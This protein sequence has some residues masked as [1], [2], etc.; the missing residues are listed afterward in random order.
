[1]SVKENP[2]KL[3]VTTEEA[4]RLRK[5]FKDEKFREMFRE[6]AQEISDPENRR[7]Y[8]KEIQLLEQERGNTVEFIHPTPYR[9][10]RTS[11]DG[12]H[13]CFIN[14]CSSEKVGKPQCQSGVSEGGRRGQR[15]SLPHS[16]HPGR[17]DT[18]PKGNKIVVYDVVFHPDTLHLAGKNQRFMDMVDNTAISAIQD[19][20]KVTLD[21]NNLRQMK[22]KYKGTPQACVIRKPIPGHKPQDPS[23]KSDPLT[24]P[25][26]DEKKPATTNKSN[27][28]P[29]SLQ[30]QPQKPPEPTKPRYTVKYRSFVDLQDYRC[31]RD[32]A[33]SPR[34]KEI[35]VTIEVPLLKSIADTSLEVKERGLLLESKDPA[36]RLELP[37]AYPVDEDGGEAKFN[38]QRGQLSVT[39]PVLPSKEVWDGMNVSDGQRSHSG[40]EEICRHED[41]EEMKEEEKVRDDGDE[42]GWRSQRKME[43]RNV[44]GSEDGEQTAESGEEMME[45]RRR[46]GSDAE[47][48]DTSVEQEEVNREEEVD[49]KEAREQSLLGNS[50]VDDEEHQNIKCPNGE[51]GEQRVK[52]REE[53]L[54]KHEEV[55]ISVEEIKTEGEDEEEEQ[56]KVERE[57]EDTEE[58]DEKESKQ[59]EAELKPETQNKEDRGSAGEERGDDPKLDE[60]CENVKK[61]IKKQKQEKGKEEL[62]KNPSTLG[63]DSVS[64]IQ[65]EAELN[66]YSP[67]ESAGNNDEKVKVGKVLTIVLKVENNS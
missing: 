49:E 12:K 10:L 51:E 44:R 33:V 66:S 19:S 11:V 34:P 8:E 55:E 18:N 35:L 47:E 62:S 31:S 36:Y 61:E 3:N 4:D 41:E 37:L 53:E 67:Q 56:E 54:R 2:D 32:S 59:S 7:Q 46:E 28:K 13:K 9:C 14:I 25:F 45:E 23:D 21:R 30:V 57:V 58:E 52:V 38:K 27:S 60:I 63:T 20:F 24:F 6:Y 40:V 48:V 26:P 65:E 29:V 15:W 16:L 5:A 50:E 64:S 17:Q 42:E 1:M 43:E 39:L 22:T